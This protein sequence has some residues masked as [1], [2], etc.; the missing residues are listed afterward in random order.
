MRLFL[1]QAVTAF[2]GRGT[3][4]TVFLLP[5]SQEA[6]KPPIPQTSGSSGELAY[7]GT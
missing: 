3:C 6:V 4:C 1:N 7:R 2:Y 5:A